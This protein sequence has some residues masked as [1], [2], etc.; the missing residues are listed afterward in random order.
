MSK[1]MTRGTHETRDCSH[2]GSLCDRDEVDVGVGVVHGPWGCANCG[3]SENPEYD[4]REDIRHD[5]DDR[6]LDQYG[7]SHHVDRPGGLAV[8]VGANVQDRGA[9]RS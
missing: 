1:K 8:L 3:W 6:V 9:T 4:C 5:G 2:C 7:A